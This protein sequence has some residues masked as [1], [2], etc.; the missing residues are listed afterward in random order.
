VYSLR[1]A[2]AAAAL[3]AAAASPA[4]AAT[5]RTTEDVADLFGQ[6]VCPTNT[7]T[8]TGYFTQVINDFDRHDGTLELHEVLNFKHVTATDQVGNTYT[9]HL[10]SALNSV[11]TLEANGGV[12][13]FVMHL[14]IVA[15]GGGM[16]DSIRVIW[17]EGPNGEIDR[18]SSTCM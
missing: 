4:S 3:S 8:L 5:I 13:T 14:N 2:L 6:I 10:N 7:Y 9:V 11:A 1:A 15:R 12:L 16:E 17:H 18:V